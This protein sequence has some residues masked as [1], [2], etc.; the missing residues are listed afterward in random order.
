[1][2]DYFRCCGSPKDLGHMN[3]CPK[4]PERVNSGSWFS[5]F[6]PLELMEHINKE[7][8]KAGESWLFLG[9]L[10]Y[11]YNYKPVGRA[12]ERTVFVHYK[13]YKTWV[14]RLEL[15]GISYSSAHGLLVR[16]YKA[17]LLESFEGMGV[18]RGWVSSAKQIHEGVIND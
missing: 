9:P 8:R 7:R 12:G 10:Y 3:G 2:S 6:T 11:K 13:G 1:M 5:P 15:D 18:G 4:S 14:Q 16:D 17:W